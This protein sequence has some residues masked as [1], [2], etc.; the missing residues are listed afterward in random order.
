[1][2]IY[3][4]NLP[5]KTDESEIETLFAQYGDVSSVKLVVDKVTGLKKGFG[6]VEMED[7]AGRKA[8]DDLNETEFKGRNIKVNKAKMRN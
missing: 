5:Y 8:I 1:M 7:S 3:V 4:G 6:F 2:N